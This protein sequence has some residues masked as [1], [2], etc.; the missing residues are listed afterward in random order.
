MG[1]VSGTA[2]QKI[3]LDGSLL[4]LE[5][6]WESD[7]GASVYIIRQYKELGDADD[8]WSGEFEELYYT[9]KVPREWHTGNYS[10]DDVIKVFGKKFNDIFEKLYKQE[11]NKVMKEVKK[12]HMF[13]SSGKMQSMSGWHKQRVRHSKARK[14]GRAG[15]VYK[16]RIRRR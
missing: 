7:E 16:S 6:N 11:Y 15:G 3:L 12:Q 4:M 5:D 8:E 1:S 14:Y 9:E 10:E 2:M 13:K